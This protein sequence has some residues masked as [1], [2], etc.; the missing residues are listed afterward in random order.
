MAPQIT[1]DTRGIPGEYFDE[2][3]REISKVHSYEIMRQRVG[4]KSKI[5][6]VNICIAHTWHK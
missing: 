4:A 6:T 5:I 2:N 3:D 1:S